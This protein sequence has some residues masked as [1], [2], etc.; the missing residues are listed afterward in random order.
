M[1]PSFLRVAL[2]PV[3]AFF[4]LPQTPQTLGLDNGSDV[5]W[6][7]PPVERPRSFEVPVLFGDWLELFALTAGLPPNAVPLFTSRVDPLVFKF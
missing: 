3:D 5:T 7:T 4:L 1:V 2:A 6:A